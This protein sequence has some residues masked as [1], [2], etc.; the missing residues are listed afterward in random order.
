M[1]RGGGVGLPRQA[2][3]TFSSADQSNDQMPP[4]LEPFD[5]R[6][7]SGS[8]AAADTVT[9]DLLPDAQLELKIEWSRTALSVLDIQQLRRGSVVPLDNGAGDPVD[10]YVSG[11]LVARGEIL[12]LDDKFCVRV[13]ELVSGNALP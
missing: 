1:E 7:L 3:A 12:V 8:P 5:L 9:L 2:T 11:R 4:G 13:A 6:D 10:V